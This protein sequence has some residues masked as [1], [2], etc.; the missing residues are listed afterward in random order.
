MV[1]EERLVYSLSP[2]KEP[3]SQDLGCVGSFF[4]RQIGFARS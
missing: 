3:T 2:E 4:K 1:S